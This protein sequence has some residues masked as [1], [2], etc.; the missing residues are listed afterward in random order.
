MRPK[1]LLIEL[2]SCG[3][4][5][6][7]DKSRILCKRSMFTIASEWESAPGQRSFVMVFEN[8]RTPLPPAEPPVP[9]R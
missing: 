9:W 6:A 1:N 4:S 3:Q 2:L 8:E 7:Y 5:K